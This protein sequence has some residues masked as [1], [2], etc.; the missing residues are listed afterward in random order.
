MYND[1]NISSLNLDFFVSDDWDSTLS[2]GGIG[3]AP[4]N[5]HDSG[6][7]FVDFMYMNGRIPRKM[8]SWSL[9]VLCSGNTTFPNSTIK[10]GA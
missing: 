6:P 5:A 10:F 3:L 1:A 8:V 7:S 4:S 9:G 2:G